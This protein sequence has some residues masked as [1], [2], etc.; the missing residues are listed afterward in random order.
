MN[1]I[2]VLHARVR[3]QMR[4]DAEITLRALLRALPRTSHRPF[5]EEFAKDSGLS[6]QVVEFSI[7]DPTATSQPFQIAFTVRRAGFLDWAAPS[8]E[9]IPPF[10]TMV[11]PAASED[12][13]G[14]RQRIEV[15]SPDA[16]RV[17]ASLQ[18]PV[19][20]TL[21]PP[22]PVELANESHSYR[23]SYEVSGNTLKAERELVRHAREL[24][25]ANAAQLMAFYRTIQA[26][27]AQKVTVNGSVR[28][29]P[30]FP[31]DATASEL[32]SAGYAAFN[33]QNY[34][35]ALAIWD[36]DGWP[37]ALLG[38]KRSRSA[39]AL[40]AYRIAWG[41]AEPRATSA[42]KHARRLAA[43][44][45][46]EE[47]VSAARL[48]AVRERSVSFPGEWPMGKAESVLVV[49]RD[50]APTSG[51]RTGRKR[52]ASWKKPLPASVFRISS[53]ATALSPCRSGCA[54]PATPAGALPR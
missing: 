49:R 23:S 41:A 29:T 19:G 25:K 44:D 31:V 43:T 45:R 33:Q 1:G 3:M 42:R 51:C 46:L 27:S 48:Q 10:P 18:L 17:R 9:L 28:A 12:D 22:V 47:F 24:L 6:G 20:Y 5:I 39:D 7:W 30:A 21:R 38:G 37:H 16:L 54:R 40:S 2:G 35:A 4:G 53:P 52:C 11:P 13:F 50:G 8:S 32:Y 15:G 34:D 26:D 14:S 36:K